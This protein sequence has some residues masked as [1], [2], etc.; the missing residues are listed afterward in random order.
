[1]VAPNLFIAGLANTVLLGGS[2]QKAIITDTVTEN[3]I[4]VQFNPEEY[5]LNRENNFAQASAPGS[6][7]PLLEI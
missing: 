6:S 4:E 2:L 3:T 5:T 1:M 7:D